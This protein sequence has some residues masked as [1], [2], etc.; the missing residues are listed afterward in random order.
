MGGMRTLGGWWS[1]HWRIPMDSFVE[2]GFSFSW[3]ILYHGL[4]PKLIYPCPMW[5]SLS[6]FFYL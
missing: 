1:A 5:Q 4:C 6:I 3:F 2:N